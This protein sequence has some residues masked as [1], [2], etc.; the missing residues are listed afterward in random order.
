M[1]VVISFLRRLASSIGAGLF[2]TCV[3]E[4]LRFSV[5]SVDLWLRMVREETMAPPPCSWS[6]Y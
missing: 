2:C 4:R 3:L 1:L 6:S 5:V